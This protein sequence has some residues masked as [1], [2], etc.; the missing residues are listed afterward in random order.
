MPQGLGGGVSK[1]DVKAAVEEALAP[2]LDKLKSIE[3]TLE[4]LKKQDKPDRN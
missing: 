4:E 2:V 3:S 1:T